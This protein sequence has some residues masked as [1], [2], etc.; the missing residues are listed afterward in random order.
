MALSIKRV[1]NPTVF[2]DKRV[3][4]ADVTFDNSYAA[5][6]EA[7][8]PQDFGMNLAVELLVP[9]PAGGLVFEPDHANN[10]LKAMYPT[11]G[12]AP[13]ALGDP[14]VVV[15]AGA[16]GV[17]SAAAQPNLTETAG[18]GK[19]VAAATDLSSITCRVLAVGV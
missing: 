6:G 8:T 10:K 13:A 15:P 12:A 5:G 9:A 17:T 16:T 7:Y 1:G 19:E 4:L 11:G 3:L 18:V 14:S 2:G